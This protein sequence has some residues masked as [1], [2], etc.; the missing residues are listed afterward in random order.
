MVAPKKQQSVPNNH[1]ERQLPMYP[2]QSNN[3]RTISPTLALAAKPNQHHHHHHDERLSDKF[4]ESEEERISPSFGESV[5]VQRS[6]CEVK[7]KSSE[8]VQKRY[9]K[10]RI[11]FYFPKSMCNLITCVRTYVCT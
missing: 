9:I 10:S 2:Y 7:P 5:P 8:E 11:L 3:Q 1:Q 4:S 6:I